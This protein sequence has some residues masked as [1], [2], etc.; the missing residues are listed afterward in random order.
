MEN[1]CATVGELNL[2]VKLTGETVRIYFFLFFFF[3]FTVLI[4]SYR[5]NYMERYSSYLIEIG[6]DRIVSTPISSLS[7]DLHTCVLP[8]RIVFARN[9]SFRPINVS[10]RKR[11]MCL[12]P[13]YL[14]INYLLDRPVEVRCVLHLGEKETFLR[15]AWPAKFS[16]N[17]LIRC[18]NKTKRL[19]FLNISR[20]AGIT[21]LRIST[22]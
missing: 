15:Q 10:S 13:S 1:Y 5:H 2:N 22:L 20:D 16:R 4:H 7:P 17:W 11:I 14:L 18:I 3:P 6:I 12:I 9:R 8:A 19:P 21:V